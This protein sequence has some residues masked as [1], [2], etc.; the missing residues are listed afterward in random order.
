MFLGSDQT[1]SPEHYP[2]FI[3]L[4]GVELAVSY[5]FEP[6]ADDDGASLDLPLALLPQ[7]DKGE[8]DGI[9]PAWREQKIAAL[10]DELPRALRHPLGERNSLRRR[11]VVASKTLEGPCWSCFLAASPSSVA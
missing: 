10:L 9:I 2:D 6:G 11:S 4:V 5:R 7:L 8:L 1:L 3:E